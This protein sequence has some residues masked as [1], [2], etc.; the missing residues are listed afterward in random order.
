MVQRAE[1]LL[2][3][4]DRV[5]T[6]LGYDACLGHFLHG[7]QLFLLAQFHFPDLAESAPAHNVLEVKVV[8][9]YRCRN[10]CEPM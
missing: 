8:L 3:V 2:F 10:Q 4:H 9:V 7:E 1:E 5:D 6:S